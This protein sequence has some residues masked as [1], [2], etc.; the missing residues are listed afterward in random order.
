MRKHILLGVL[1]T[2]SF[3]ALKAQQ[4]RETTVNLSVS[5]ANAGLETTKAIRQCHDSMFLNESGIV[6][7]AETQRTIDRAENKAKTDAERGVVIVLK[8]LF[9]AKLNTNM[10]RSIITMSGFSRDCHERLAREADADE[11]IA[12]SEEEQRR[13]RVALGF[14]LHRR[15]YLGTPTECKSI[16]P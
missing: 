9:Q 16:A 2:I 4:K 6:L 10:S 12:A 8:A 7:P 3:C 14:I 11:A 5:F 15:S 13:C 1:L